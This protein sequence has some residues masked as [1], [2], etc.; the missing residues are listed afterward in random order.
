MGLMKTKTS[1]EVP[2]E[3]SWA[4]CLMDTNTTASDEA[5]VLGPDCMMVLAENLAVDRG[6][7]PPHWKHVVECRKCG[8]MPSDIPYSGKLDACPWCHRASPVANMRIEAEKAKNY[9][10]NKDLDKY[11][12]GRVD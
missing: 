10:G 9:P 8:F 11:M 6:V 7:I 3:E 12:G 4:K 2:V 1:K 5:R